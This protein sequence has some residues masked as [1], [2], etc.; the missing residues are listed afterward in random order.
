MS[1]P[2]SIIIFVIVII[3]AFTIFPHLV[4]IFAP[5]YTTII[6]TAISTNLPLIAVLVDIPLVNHTTGPA[7][8]VRV[9]IQADPITA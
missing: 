3:I 6:I 7:L 4:T 8:K 2:Q 9:V 1:R 5:A